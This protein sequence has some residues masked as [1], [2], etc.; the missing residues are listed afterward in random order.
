[1]ASMEK[2][3]AYPMCF[4]GGITTTILGIKNGDSEIITYGIII[5]IIFAISTIWW[6]N[7]INEGW[8]E[9]WIA[10]I[11]PGIVCVLALYFFW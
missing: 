10:S 6:Y 1:M 4:W 3:L 8:V 9:F 5:A 2:S 7:K 11:V